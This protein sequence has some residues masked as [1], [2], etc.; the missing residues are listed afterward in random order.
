MPQFALL[1]IPVFLILNMLSGALSPL[2]S[3]PQPFQ[4]AIQV[5]PTVHYVKFAQSVLYRAAG[6]D[7][8]WPQI[9]VLAVLGS[10]FL[11]IALARFRTMLAKS[12]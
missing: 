5:S 4:V 8:V 7:V 6:L 12:G 10:V 2:E 11:A 3:M 9:A 1:A